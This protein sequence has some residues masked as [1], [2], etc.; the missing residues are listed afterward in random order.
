MNQLVCVKIQLFPFNSCDSSVRLFDVTAVTVLFIFYEFTV[1]ANGASPL[2][3]LW[4][5]ADI[6]QS[7][8]TTN[9]K[10]RWET[11]VSQLN[12]LMH[13]NSLFCRTIQLLFIATAIVFD[14]LA[15]GPQHDWSALARFVITVV[16]LQRITCI[17]LLAECCYLLRLSVL[18]NVFERCVVTNNKKTWERITCTEIY[19]RWLMSYER[20]NTKQTTFIPFFFYFSFFFPPPCV[21]SL[22][23][24]KLFRATH[25][26]GLLQLFDSFLFYSFWWRK[27]HSRKSCSIFVAAM[28]TRFLFSSFVD[29]L[30]QSTKFV[31]ECGGFYFVQF[32]FRCFFVE[33]DRLSKSMKQLVKRGTLCLFTAYARSHSN[34]NEH[35]NR[36]IIA[37]NQLMQ[38][39]TVINTAFRRKCTED[40]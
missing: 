5:F 12:E 17:V 32:Q 13:F 24:G 34:W 9:I 35:F 15:L 11:N 22:L 2:C 8:M 21:L 3:L 16:R 31:G 20:T 40:V 14:V 37:S 28:P 7:I 18:L 23:S 6:S 30:N 10:L 1:Y 29:K 38:N 19:G 26:I 27:N 39:N 4:N 36:L 33:L 25:K